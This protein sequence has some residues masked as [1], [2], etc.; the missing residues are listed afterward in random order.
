[1]NVTHFVAICG[2]LTSIP[3]FFAHIMV[4]DPMMF[5]AVPRVLL[6]S[7]SPTLHFMLPSV[8]GGPGGCFGAIGNYKSKS[9]SFVNF[10]F[11]GPKGVCIPTTGP[12]AKFCGRSKLIETGVGVATARAQGPASRRAFP[13][14][15]R[16]NFPFGPFRHGKPNPVTE[17]GFFAPE[18]AGGPK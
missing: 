11:N 7:S 6:A 2:L 15:G 14:F 18:L 1:M 5:I 17:A 8:I 16:R 12:S 9:R 3:A 10:A 4:P 13:R